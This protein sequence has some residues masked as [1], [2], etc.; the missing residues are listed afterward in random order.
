LIK[1]IA[2]YAAHWEQL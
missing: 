1:I 2:N